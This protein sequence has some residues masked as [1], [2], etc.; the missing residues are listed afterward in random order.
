MIKLLTT[1]PF[2]INPMLLKYGITLVYSEFRK[3]PKK[4]R[5]KTFISDFY[6]IQPDLFWFL[7]DEWLKPWLLARL[8]KVSPKTKFIM[9][10]GDQRGKVP[11]LIMNRKNYIDMLFVNNEDPKQVKMYNKIGIHHVKP[12]YSFY[13]QTL[14]NSSLVPKMDVVFGGNNFNPKK[15]PLGK[16]RLATVLAIYKNYNM[17]IYGN[18]WPIPA[19]KIVTSRDSYNKVLHN[20]KITLGINHYNIIKYYDR[21]L[22]DCLSTGRLHL[23]YYIPGIEND[24][25]N[26]KHL[27]WFKTI[28][29]CIRLIKYYLNN[30]AKRE[31]IGKAGL[32]K[33]LQDHSSEARAK[34]FVD[35]ISIL[36]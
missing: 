32:A 9:W 22:L 4:E 20:A 16:L 3:Q 26:H 29:Q 1:K 35:N 5:I 33:L 15:F 2:A 12:F 25:K 31:R 19:E 36:L 28:P 6:K 21:R 23:T 34:K 14:L 13:H 27:V 10:Y 18:G 30:A 11:D 17:K 24:F 8:K 7:K